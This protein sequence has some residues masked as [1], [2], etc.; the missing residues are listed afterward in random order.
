MAGGDGDRL[1]G[2]SEQ[3]GTTVSCG[4]LVKHDG[5]DGF[6]YVMRF[7]TIELLCGA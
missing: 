6:I 4:K 2:D 3:Q 5:G 1:T 7:L